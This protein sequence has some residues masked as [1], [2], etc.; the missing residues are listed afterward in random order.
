MQTELL[1]IFD[2]QHREIGVASRTDV[3][4][5]GYWH[6]TF[7]FWLIEKETDSYNIYFQIRSDE[8]K[9]YP[10]LLDITAA[11]HLLAHETIEDGI[12]EVEEEIG[13]KVTPEELISLGVIKNPIITDSLID[14]EFSHVFLYE[15]SVSPTFKL[16]QEEVSGIAKADFYDYYDLCLGQKTEIQIDGFLQEIPF[17]KMVTIKDFVPHKP[18]YLEIVAESIKAHIK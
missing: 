10:S 12:R 9:D 15:S 11:G 16:Q 3:H 17:S 1:K 6:E 13:I 4:K 5:L 8:K 18:S 14:N 7:H 2:E